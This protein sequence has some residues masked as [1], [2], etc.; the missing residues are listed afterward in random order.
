MNIKVQIN[1][2]SELVP[3]AIDALLK[4]IIK[5]VPL[6]E[7]EIYQIRLMLEEAIA[8]GV[9]HGNKFSTDL[10]VT[11]SLSIQNNVL[12]MAVKDEGKGFNPRA[13]PDPVKNEDFKPSGRG[14]YLIQKYA[15]DVKFNDTGN[16]IIITKR[17]KGG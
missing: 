13:V 9:C 17:I 14:I 1:S 8:N 4:Q 2:I 12:T 16:E 11:V 5:A 3:S 15:D 7:D 6:S 10:K